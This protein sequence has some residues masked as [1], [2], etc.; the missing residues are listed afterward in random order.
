MYKDFSG[1]A[2][3]GHLSFQEVQQR[4]RYDI[5]LKDIRIFLGKGTLL[6]KNV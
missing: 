5:S 4:C 6:A 3:D 1:L 2:Q